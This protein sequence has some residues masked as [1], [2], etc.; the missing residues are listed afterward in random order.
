MLAPRIIDFRSRKNKL[1]F[2]SMLALTLHPSE[3]RKP[4]HTVRAKVRSSPNEPGKLLF[5]FEVLGAGFVRWPN[6]GFA[7]NQNLIGENCFVGQRRDE[8]WKAT[9][10]EGFLGSVGQASYV[11]WNFSLNG[12]WAAYHFTSYRTGMKPAE[13]PPP[14]FHLPQLRTDSSNTRTV[15]EIEADVPL[16]LRGESRGLQVSLTAV[17]LETDDDKPFYWAIEHWREKPDFHARE[18]FT[19][20]P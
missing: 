7:A 12:D 10:F 17:V 13:V 18:S 5:L 15:V 20:I 2:E 9:C 6:V 11:E 1:A 16:E 14:I 3:L 4:R 19:L 8:L